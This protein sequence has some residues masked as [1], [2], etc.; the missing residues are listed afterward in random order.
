MKKKF[1]MN[2]KIRAMGSGS[3]S[4]GASRMRAARLAAEGKSVEED[5]MAKGVLAGQ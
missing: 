1:G 3:I 4:A 5:Q 2:F